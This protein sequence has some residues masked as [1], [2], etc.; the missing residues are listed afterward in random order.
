[1]RILSIGSRGPL[2][3][4]LQLTLNNAGNYTLSIDGIFGANTEQALKNFQKSNNLNANGNANNITWQALL[5][6]TS[7]PTTIEYSYDIMML[8]LQALLQKH[9]FLEMGN[10]GISML[11]R[12]I[13]YIKIGN[14]A[15]E[16]IYVAATHANEWITS[17]VLMKFLED[18]ADAYEN[19]KIIFDINAVDLYNQGSIYIVPM[20]NPDGVDL[21]T[22]DLQSNTSAYASALEISK[23]YPG[24]RF[25]SG[26]KSNI[27]GIDLNLQFPALWENA[28]EIKYA[29]GFT[30]PAPRDF[31]GDYPLQSPET[32]AIYDFIINHDFSLMLSYHSQGEV[33][34]WQFS[35]FNPQ[36]AQQIGEKFSDL[37]GYM[38]SDTPYSSAFAGLKNW[39]IK[40]Y[41]RPGYTIE[42]GR[43]TN[44]LPIS[45]FST[46]YNDNIGILINALL[47]A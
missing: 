14:G 45:Q 21:V 32:I 30:S 31:V 19:N 26:W 9:D 25:P 42:V 10:I 1:M 44:P 17:P 36:N 3:K 20:L 4:F 11:E 6:Y 13:P 37:S 40:N 18:Y 2:V 8:N 38:L 43:G 23:N 47:L 39:F 5:P 35:D 46:I 16:V 12:N 15:T 22:G 24:V 28:R 7:V 33:I 34:Y 41:N 29:Q 27:E